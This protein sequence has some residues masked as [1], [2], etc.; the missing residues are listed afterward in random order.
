MS[1]SNIIVIEYGLYDCMHLLNVHT[2]CTIMLYAV[3]AIEMHF[4]LLPPKLKRDQCT[5]LVPT[6]MREDDYNC[7]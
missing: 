4:L 5:L 7:M 6:A 3:Y 2:K 1:G